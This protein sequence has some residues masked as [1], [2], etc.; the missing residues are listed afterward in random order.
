M[1]KK[2]IK[3]LLDRTCKNG[4]LQFNGKF[5]QQVDGVAMGLPLAPAIADICMNWLLEEV[6]KKINARFKLF[7]YVDDLFLAFDSSKDIDD[8][9]N[10]FKNSIYQRTR[11]GKSINL[12]GC[13]HHEN[14]GK[15][16]NQNL[17][18]TFIHGLVPHEAKLCSS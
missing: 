7:W 18:E 3:I 2:H 8:T 14:K 1:N 15:C 9:L 5:Y 6:C 12:F 16:R 11:S 4:T 17:Q 10:A 13:P